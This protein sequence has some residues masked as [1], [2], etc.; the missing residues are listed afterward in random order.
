MLIVSSVLD[1]Y[2]NNG[3]STDDVLFNEDLPLAVTLE[4]KMASKSTF[5]ALSCGTISGPKVHL[6]L[7]C[8][9]VTE[10]Q[11][12]FEF[13]CQCVQAVTVKLCRSGEGKYCSTLTFLDLSLSLVDQCTLCSGNVSW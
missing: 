2:S 7:R 9:Y 8:M 3:P 6:D 10:V 5:E 11:V 1:S 4:P 13:Y 12:R